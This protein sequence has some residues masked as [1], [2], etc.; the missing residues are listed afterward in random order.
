MIAKS[1]QRTTTP[2]ASTRRP[3]VLLVQQV[4]DDGLQMYAE[5]LRYS[6]CA[7]ITVSN[8]TAAL[9][10][11]PRADIV[12]TDILLD[13]ATDGVELVSRLRR[14]DRTRHKPI[15]VLTASGWR[16]ERERAAHAGCDLFLSKPCLPA[17]LLREV[18]RLLPT[19]ADD[20]AGSRP[21]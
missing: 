11:A 17:D 21:Q 19:L 14:G 7:A 5:F 12:V 6:G 2:V 18:R 9:K 3:V 8:A 1:R 4:R 10:F 16:Q 15:V 13:D 20:P